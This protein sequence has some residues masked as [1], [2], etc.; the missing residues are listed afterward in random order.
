MGSYTEAN[1]R[2]LFALSLLRLPIGTKSSVDF[3]VFISAI[4]IAEMSTPPSLLA[5][6]ST[7]AKLCVSSMYR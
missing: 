6:E 5:L 1:G 2:A 7:W 3:P 4:Q